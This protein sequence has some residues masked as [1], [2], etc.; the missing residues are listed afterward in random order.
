VLR[1]AFTASRVVTD[2]IALCILHNLQIK[3]HSRPVWFPL[4]SFCLH[5][6]SSMGSSPA[7]AAVLLARPHSRP[8]LS[9]VSSPAPT[10]FPSSTPAVR[11]ILSPSA[12]QPGATHV[13]VGR[14]RQG[15]FEPVRPRYF[16]RA[17]RRGGWSS[18]PSAA[19]LSSLQRTSP[20]ELSYPLFPSRSC[21]SPIRGSATS[22]RLRPCSSGA[23]RRGSGRREPRMPSRSST[24]LAELAR[25][26]PDISC[27][28]LGI[29]SSPMEINGLAHPLPRLTIPH[30]KK[31]CDVMFRFVL[32]IDEIM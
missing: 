30:G 26:P 24:Q 9:K 22:A 25:S 15:A 6:C 10:P 4:I 7:A 5:V 31:C 20:L 14:R 21:P 28:K 18:S 1:P 11:S 27:R 17:A 23:A 29:R 32:H 19:V 13:Y 2:G 16:S 8:P 3:C 12:N